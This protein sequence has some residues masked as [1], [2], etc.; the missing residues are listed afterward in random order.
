[1]KDCKGMNILIINA[2]PRRRG[3]IA[4]MLGIMEEE[5]KACGH[6]VEQILVCKQD[7]RPCTGCMY[8]RT[9][10][11]CCLPE[12]DAVR[13]LEKI[14]WADALI[15]G[16]PCYW[17]NMNGHL[18]MLFDRMVYGMMGES[19]RGI[20]QALHKGKKAI[21]VSTCTTP[22]PWNI[23]FNQTSGVVKALKEIL[24]WSG[25]KVKGVIQKGG[26]KKNPNISMREEARCRSVVR[27]LS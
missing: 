4:R 12:D 17:G 18:K 22:F 27:K 9:H 3:L 10:D 1:M 25:F 5:A 6:T 7:F 21:I 15:I 8:C 19:P 2:S 20:P 13:T 24:K 23:L 11:A 26:T 14:R 16:S